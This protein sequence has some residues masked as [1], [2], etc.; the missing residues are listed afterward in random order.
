[1]N[2]YTYNQKFSESA[3]FHKVKKLGLKEIKETNNVI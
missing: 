1:M 2:K 3:V